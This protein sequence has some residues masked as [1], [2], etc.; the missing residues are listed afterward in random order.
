MNRRKKI[1]MI[2]VCLL[3]VFSFVIP[4]S[5]ADYQNGDTVYDAYVY[6]DGEP[7]GIQ[8]P[9]TF[10]KK[11]TE[12]FQEISDL[13]FCKEN[14]NLYVADCQA[15]SIVVLNREFEKKYILNSFDNHGTIDTFTNCSG[16]CIR[17]GVLYVADSGNS[18]IVTFRAD[19][20]S[21]LRTFEKPEITQLGAGYTYKPIRLAVGITGQMY[22]V[23]EGVNSG[24][25]V[26]DANGEFQSFIGAPEV[27]TDFLDE[28]WK[29]F[30]TKTQREALTKS[31]PTEYNSILFDENGFLYATT[32]SEGVQPIVRLNLQGIDILKYA[33]GEMPAGDTEYI[34]TSS[35]FVDVCVN[36]N[37]VYYALDS[38]L[39]HIFTYNS[40]GKLL[41]A[42]GRN[43][44]QGG[45]TN[46]PMAIECVGE[47]LLIG[48]AVTGYINVYDCTQ[49]G[50]AILTADATM[51]AGDY[52]VAKECWEKVL[53]E[54]G[55]YTLAMESLGKLAL[56]A[57][58]YKGSME[59]AKSS[60]DKEA[61]SD[62]FRTYR[63]D[64]IYENY[65]VLLLALAGVIII[66][67][68]YKKFLSGNKWVQ[69]FRE[70]KLGKGLAYAKYCAFHPFDGFWCLKREKRGNLLTANVIVALFLIVYL[71]NVQFSGY[72]FLNGQPEDV[73]AIVSL[74]AAVVL[75]V[76]YCAGNWCFTSLMD[77]KGTMKDIYISTATAL[78]PYI[79]GGIALF[80][81]SQ[82]LSLQESFLYSTIKVILMI[83]IAGLIFFGMMM[84]H[85][86]SLGQGIKTMILTI[87][88]MALILFVALVFFNLVDDMVQFFYSIYRELLYRN[89]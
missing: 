7:M 14:Q 70:S 4:A 68:L 9:Y 18:R 56:Y 64:F 67:L 38:Y 79:G 83:W 3:L 45:T 73:D 88:G 21:F 35:A 44:S 55:T 62:A 50:K 71:M 15:N 61:Y 11:L 63:S 36:S 42:F 16:V 48:D 47:Q 49:F 26:L 76:T 40:D 23:A 89:I 65:L 43:G 30:M 75:M 77:G 24:F 13:F 8:M 39:G 78:Y 60:A 53:G 6:D 59:Y 31:V 33:D 82:V 46:S 51:T 2:L 12:K 57:S 54:C 10:E 58:N 87:V 72:L 29:M 81:M 17:D 25:I 34:P 37:G 52:E 20:Y 84:T 1:G 27:K 66:F 41:F 69:Q 86:Y 85:D 74:L 80:A 32:K 28:I 22:V 19:D 5:A